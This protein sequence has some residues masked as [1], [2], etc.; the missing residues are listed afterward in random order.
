MKRE[1]VNAI[2]DSQVNVFVNFE[3]GIIDEL[4]EFA[5]QTEVQNETMDKK[6]VDAQKENV[7]T[8]ALLLSWK[9]VFER[10]VVNQ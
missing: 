10:E 3:E 2:K 6:C 7:N 8:K 5:A 9:A 1:Q 4:V